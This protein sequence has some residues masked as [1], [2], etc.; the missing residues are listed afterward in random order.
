[1]T[2]K[3]M[4]EKNDIK[5]HLEKILDEEMDKRDPDIIIQEDATTF[6]V[7][8]ISKPNN[9]NERCL[10]MNTGLGGFNLFL[11]ATNYNL[12]LFKVSYN[13]VILDDKQKNDLCQQ[14]KIKA[15]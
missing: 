12:T 2:Y 5:N 13:G 14:V 4:M 1:M 9:K 8:I 6:Y 3:E 10:S 7:K 11:E 15:K